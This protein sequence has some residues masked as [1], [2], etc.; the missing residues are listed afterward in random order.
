MTKTK[1]KSCYVDGH[2]REEVVRDRKRLFEELEEIKSDCLRVDKES[3]DVINRN[4]AKLLLLSQDESC[5]HSNETD[6]RLWTDGTDNFPPQKSQGRMIMSSDF[7]SVDG[8]LCLKEGS[9]HDV[10]LM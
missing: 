10:V 3:L 7:V 6:S 4:D 8:L 1:K 2:E 5:K 9:A